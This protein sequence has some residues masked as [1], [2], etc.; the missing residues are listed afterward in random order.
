M[1]FSRTLR[2]VASAIYLLNFLPTAVLAAGSGKS[3]VGSADGDVQIQ[4]DIPSG[5]VTVLRPTELE[6]E[7]I[8]KRANEGD[9]AAQMILSQ[10][11]YALKN[12]PEGERWLRQ[13]AKTGNI[14]AEYSLGNELVS[15]LR[16][17]PLRPDEGIIWLKLAA[18][19]GYP[20]AQHDLSRSYSLGRGVE[21]SVLEAYAWLLIALR[22]WP[23]PD[24]GEGKALPLL[25]KQLSSAEI[26]QA[27][28]RAKNYVPAT[29]DRNPFVDAGFIKLKAISESNGKPIALIN[30]QAFSNGEQKK[31]VWVVKPIEVRCLEIRAHSVVVATEP[32]W[33]RGEMRLPR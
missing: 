19:E 6:M 12:I 25:E 1:S 20:G 15:A 24:D 21:K 16:G 18:Y 4:T 10:V 29:M 33:Q 28:T 7:A 32:Y 14:F 5:K 3:T 9:A 22:S 2:V 26:E 30:D 23:F 8:S 31:V 11:Q 27:K 17:N 13:A